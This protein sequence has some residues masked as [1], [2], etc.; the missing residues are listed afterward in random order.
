MFSASFP[1]AA[2]FVFLLSPLLV[3][4]ADSAPDK[5]PASTVAPAPAAGASPGAVKPATDPNDI[6]AEEV[7]GLLRQLRKMRAGLDAEGRRAVAEA[8][9]ALGPAS[10]SSAE[11][12]SLWLASVRA[13]EFDKLNRKS[14]DF[15]EWRKKNDDKLHDAGFANALRLQCRYLKLCLEADTPEKAAAAGPAI[16]ALVEEAI[17]AMPQCAQY[18]PLLREDA[19]SS[20]TAKKLGVEKQ[21]PEGW[22]KALLSLD[23]H[24]ERFSADARASNPASLPAL[25]EVRLRLERAH[26]EALDQTARVQRRKRAPEAPGRRPSTARDSSRDESDTKYVE[27]FET[28]K[29]PSLLWAMGED[30]YKAGMRRR[31]IEALFGV[32]RKYPK[33]TK[34]SEWVDRVTTMAEELA[35]EGKAPA[36]ATAGGAPAADAT[37]GA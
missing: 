11:A 8:L 32:L 37:A 20:V 7:E 26:A 28:D 2:P 23:G 21:C 5:V 36:T 13:M 10:S 1:K 18:A 15:E 30:Y 29:Y 12:V 4:A 25:W 17:K 22:S 6:S 35:A 19:F 16:V 3:H 24:F 9:K 33:H 34:A 14:A 31:G 27:A